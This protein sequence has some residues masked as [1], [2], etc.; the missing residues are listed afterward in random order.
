MKMGVGVLVLMLVLLKKGLLKL[1]GC[2]FGGG[3]GGGVGFEYSRRAEVAEETAFR[4]ARC[5]GS[6]NIGGSG[7]LNCSG[8][9]G[10]MC[11]NPDPSPSFVDGV[12]MGRGDM[13]DG[14]FGL[15]KNEGLAGRGVSNR[16]L[17]DR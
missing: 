7:Y 9:V 3:G 8:E 12:K 6:W 4:R 15:P 10:R 2:V 16:S 17:V 11:P 13:Y 5:E 14:G 1:K